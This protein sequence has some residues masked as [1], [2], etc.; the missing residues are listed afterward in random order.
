VLKYATGKLSCNG[1]NAAM[2][3]ERFSSAPKPPFW[4]WEVEDQ[5]GKEMGLRNRYRYWKQYRINLQEL[6]RC[7][8]RDLMD[9]GITRSDIRR[10]AR[11]AA[12]T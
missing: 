1:G 8:D 10:V 7:S 9:L 11:D 3:H 6:Q 12:R 2:Q 5:K 4:L